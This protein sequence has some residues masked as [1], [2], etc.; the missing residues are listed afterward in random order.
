ML[1]KAGRLAEMGLEW[2]S[3]LKL[4]IRCYHFHP[5]CVILAEY[6]KDTIVNQIMSRLKI[7][8][9]QITLLV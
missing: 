2:K 8:H 9:P 4:L 7:F 3:T 1:A 6:I 5:P